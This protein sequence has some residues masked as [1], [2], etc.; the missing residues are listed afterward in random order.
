MQYVTFNKDTGKILSI[1]NEVEK[2]AN[3]IQVSYEDV[4]SI[5][6]GIEPSTNYAVEYNPKTKTLEFV[7]KAENIFDAVTVSEFIYEIPE[8]EINEP[9]ILVIQDIPNTCWK[10][11]VGKTLRKNIK[12]KGISLNTTMMFS[13]TAK[14]DPN[15]L[16]KTLFVH[17]GQT[18]N[19]NY[20]I[21]PFSM[22][23][24]TT[25]EAISIYT[26]RRFDTYQFARIYE[27]D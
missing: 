4:K 9:D 15:I 24:E 3:Y 11:S 10:I 6:K 20:C 14:G 13:I 5:K 25:N 1:G 8:I 7:S 21:V 12:E 23:F 16:Y 27:Q 26:A 17:T 18:L 22:P 19:D 2:D